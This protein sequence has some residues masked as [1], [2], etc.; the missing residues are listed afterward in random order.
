M[1]SATAPVSSLA[2]STLTSLQQCNKVARSPNNCGLVRVLLGE[3]TFSNLFVM[4]FT[5]HC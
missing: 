4:L 1:N 3:L 5:I 2:I